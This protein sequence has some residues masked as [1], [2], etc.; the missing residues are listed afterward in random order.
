MGLPLALDSVLGLVAGRRHEL[1]DH[2]HPGSELF[3]TGLV[4]H[5]LADF[6]LVIAHR[7]SPGFGLAALRE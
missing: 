5:E 6:E 1:C 3:H 2:I 7:F 4:V